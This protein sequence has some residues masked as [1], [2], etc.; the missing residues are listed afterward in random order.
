CFDFEP[1]PRLP[2]I[3]GLA[4]PVKLHLDDIFSN[5]CKEALNYAIEK[6]NEKGANLIFERIKRTN[7]HSA[8]LFYI[9]F[10]AQNAT[11]DE[12]KTYQTRVFRSN[13]FFIITHILQWC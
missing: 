5:S 10:N 3:L 7:M 13:S 2:K 4:Y 1:L 9:T 12:V 11:T 8:S 6:E